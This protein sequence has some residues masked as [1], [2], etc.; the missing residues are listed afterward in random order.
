MA[1]NHAI[2]TT[3][4]DSRWFTYINDDDHLM[5]GFRQAFEAAMKPGAPAIVYGQ[6]EMVTL[7]D[8]LITRVAIARKYWHIG[9]YYRIGI[10]PFT[11]QGTV[12]STAVFKQF[13]G[14]DTRY[15]LIADTDFFQRAFNSRVK[16]QFVN[17]VVGRY[18][19]RPGQLS[20]NIAVQSQELREMLG[21]YPPPIARWLSKLVVVVLGGLGNAG[22]FMERMEINDSLRIRGI[23]QEFQ[24]G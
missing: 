12:I 20:S 18:R 13:N 15:S 24:G 19:I 1:L 8:K 2:R 7:D 23:V 21:Y 3:A 5:P 11:Q 10:V 9:H 4:S 17:K 14:F 22:I 6:V 16:M